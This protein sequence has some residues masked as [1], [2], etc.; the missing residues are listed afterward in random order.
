MT[1]DFIPI[2]STKID[3]DHFLLGTEKA[4]GRNV[5][6]SLDAKN[7]SP[8][9]SAPFIAAV[10]EFKNKNSDAIK[11]FRQYTNGQHTYV[12]FLIV[13]D[14]ETFVELPT[15]HIDFTWTAG[16]G[17]TT[18]IATGSMYQWYFFLLACLTEHVSYNTRVL[19]MK[20]MLWFEQNDFGECWGNFRKE[21]LLDKTYVL[22]AK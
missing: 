10:C 6:A 14:A 11:A 21:P 19:G 17:C 16:L 5:S 1:P 4:L 15:K 8:V 9:G 2:I 12:G 18:I 22:V 20:L 3:W 13:C 7:L